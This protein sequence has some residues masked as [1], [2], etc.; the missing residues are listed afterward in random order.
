MYFHRDQGKVHS[1]QSRNFVLLLSIVKH[2][3][4]A[5]RCATR[6]NGSILQRMGLVDL[7]MS[8]AAVKRS[9]LF[10]AAGPRSENEDHRLHLAVKGHAPALPS[11]T[12]FRVR[13]STRDNREAIGGQYREKMKRRH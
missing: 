8:V 7:P 6:Q 2:P 5:L 13:V 3:A 11:D 10:P 9:L 12:I 1:P 4:V